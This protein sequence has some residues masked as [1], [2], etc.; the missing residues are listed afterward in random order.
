MNQNNIEVSI[1]NLET[2]V[3]QLVKKLFENYNG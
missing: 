3:G 1:K 2:Q